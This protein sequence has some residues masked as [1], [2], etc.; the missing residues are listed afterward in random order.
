MVMGIRRSLRRWDL[1]PLILTSV[2]ALA[3]ACSGA[4]GAGPQSPTPSTEPAARQASAD[5]P[6]RLVL[7]PAGP[8]IPPAPAS[9]DAFVSAQPPASDCSAEALATALEQTTPDGRDAALASLESCSSWPPGAL[10][11]LRTEL[12]PAECADVLVGDFLA[13]E[14]PAPEEVTETLFALGLAARLR[15]LAVEPPAPPDVHERSVLQAYFQNE[16]FPWIT[17]QAGTIHQLAERGSASLRGY[18]RGIVAI[19]AGMADMRF[20]EIARAVPI[21]TEMREDAELRDTYYASLDE[22][23]EPRKRRGRDA[24]LVGLREF[25]EVGVLQDSRL[26]AARALLSRVYGGRRIDALDRLLLPPLPPAPST[27]ATSRIAAR[28]P[29]F[30]VSWLLPEAETQKDLLRAFLERGLPRSTRLDLGSRPL[31]TDTAVLLARGHLELGR[32]YFRAESFATARKILEI[33]ASDEAAFV[34]AVATSLMAGPR[35]AVEMFA[36][37]PYFAKALGNLEALDALAAAA[38]PWSGQASFDAAYLREL[39]A[40]VEDAAY[41]QDLAERYER[42]AQSLTEADRQE[43]Q[44]R[45]AAARATVTAIAG[46]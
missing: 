16:L 34:S 13:G 30:Y 40:P 23:L 39:V 38:G 41:W 7:P 20:V 33:H 12:V 5:E 18:A 17:E 36:R 31:D 37:G 22:A 46:K 35:D 19:E 21:P 43:A 27:D 26:T 14:T 6:Q 44:A 8:R 32:T 24:A 11:A 42:A 29:T 45:A 28:L 2:G 25:A 3:L 10:R 15:R 9:C 4:Q 1:S